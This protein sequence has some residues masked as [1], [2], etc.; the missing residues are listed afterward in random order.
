MRQGKGLPTDQLLVLHLG[1]DATAGGHFRCRET[2]DP[3]VCVHQTLVKATM[4]TGLGCLWAGDGGAGGW[5]QD[6]AGV[7]PS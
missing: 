3:L 1:A 5:G 2:L 6:P 4:Q 7:I